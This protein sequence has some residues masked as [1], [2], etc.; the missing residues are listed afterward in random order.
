MI[1]YYAYNSNNGK[2]FF[3]GTKMGAKSNAT[4]RYDAF[5]SFRAYACTL[6]VLSHCGIWA[7]GGLGNGVFFTLSGFFAVLPFIPNPE[8]RL[9]SIPGLLK[10]YFSKLLRIF[11]PLW[12]SLIFVKY[13]TTSPVFEPGNF[14]T[15]RSFVL[16]ALM[17]NPFGHLWFLQQVVLF[18]IIAPLFIYLAILI[19]FILSKT[20]L[21]QRVAELIVALI[22][23]AI[24]II[25]YKYPN[26]IPIY[27]RANGNPNG[28]HLPRFLIGTACAYFYR[29]VDYSYITKGERGA[30]FTG[31][32]RII[33]FVC[34]VTLI[35]ILA[36]CILTSRDFLQ[37]IDP[38][39][40][41]YRIGW[42]GPML[43]CGATFV[44]I[45]A[46]I[47]GKDALFIR[48]FSA[49]AISYIGKISFSI[50]II[51]FFLIPFFP[52]ESP[53]Q[54]FVP[55]YVLSVGY[56]F[57]MDRYVETPLEKLRKR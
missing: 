9:F 5:D 44:A 34:S 45:F 7:Q 12:I 16:N 25:T 19:K 55:V 29:F 23:L 46:L 3:K 13:F 17:L 37:Y 53:I 31:A 2:T 40:Y 4:P 11:P 50:Y 15:E 52:A 6:V 48:A 39:Y 49:K 27:C 30:K 10:Y 42:D 20:P 35:V 41:E 57:L 36:L 24:T 18:I 38:A 1:L 32:R 8:K 21:S 51:H 54:T 47:F 26:I 28:F 56:A 14:T 43:V 33:N 22:F